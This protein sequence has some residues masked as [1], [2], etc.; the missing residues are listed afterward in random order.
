MGGKKEEMD[1]L[2]LKKKDLSEEG[3]KLVVLETLR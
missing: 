3:V 2:S 1:K